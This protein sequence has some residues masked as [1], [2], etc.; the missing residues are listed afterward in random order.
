MKT[1]KSCTRLFSLGVHKE[2]V[3]WE[4]LWT[5]SSSINQKLSRE[6]TQT[7]YST[8]T[9]KY[10]LFHLNVEILLLGNFFQ[11]CTFEIRKI[12]KCYLFVKKTSIWELPYLFHVVSRIIPTLVMI[13]SFQMLYFILFKTERLIKY[14]FEYCLHLKLLWNFSKI[15]NLDKK[16]S[17]RKLKG[18]KVK[19]RLKD[20]NFGKVSIFEGAWNPC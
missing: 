20:F 7:F 11:N 18:L 3:F 15:K 1:Y 12:T 17:R 9:P 14:F 5:V 13:L 8:S 2:Q 16:A 4:K 19:N 10:F 6:F